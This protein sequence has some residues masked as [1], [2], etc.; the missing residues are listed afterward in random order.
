MYQPASRA[1][2]SR[3]IAQGTKPNK[4]VNK[5]VTVCYVSNLRIEMRKRHFHVVLFRMLQWIFQ[6]DANY[7]LQNSLPIVK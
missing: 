6:R 2:V 4:T 7:L 1:G 3:P 5:K